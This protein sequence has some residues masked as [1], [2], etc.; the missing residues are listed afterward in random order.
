MSSELLLFKY[1]YLLMFINIYPSCYHVV[2]QTPEDKTHDVLW[3]NLQIR[4]EKY[5]K[6]EG[7]LISPHQSL[8]HPL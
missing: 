5:H 2:F 4:L 1:I 7:R 3:G 6:W 8:A